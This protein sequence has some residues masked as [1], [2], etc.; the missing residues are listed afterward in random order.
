MAY[1]QRLWSAMLGKPYGEDMV[2][3]SREHGRWETE[4]QRYDVLDAYRRNDDLYGRLKGELKIR[5]YE[6]YQNIRNP[7]N[8]LIEFYASELPYKI[9]EHLE[10]GKNDTLKKL[11]QQVNEWSN[12]TDRSEVAARMFATH[13][14]LF[15]KIESSK[16]KAQVRKHLLDPRHVT[17]FDTD[18]R[19]T[20]TYLRLDIPQERRKADEVEEYTRT[21]VWDKPSERYFVYEHDEGPDADLEDL[22]AP[23]YSAVLTATPPDNPDT[24]WTGF[25]FIPVVHRKLKDTGGERGEGVFQHALDPIDQANY[26]ATKLMQMLFPKT[27]WKLTRQPGPGGITL[28]AAR[29]EQEAE[30]DQ[31]LSRLTAS[32]QES[33]GV[34]EE[35]NQQET[36]RLPAGTDLSP[37]VPALDFRS[38]LEALQAHMA[39][40]E[41]EM[42][43]LAY[44]RLRDMTEVSGVAARVLLDDVITRFET[45]RSKFED[46]EVR[47]NKMALTIAQVLGIEGY[48]ALPENAYTSGALDHGFTLYELFPVNPLDL[49]RTATE[50]ARA[51]Q[52]WEK[53]G[54]TLYARYLRSLGYDDEE[55]QQIAQASAERENPEDRQRAQIDGILSGNIPIGGNGA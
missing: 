38:H 28:P 32:E 15:I 17:D 11:I 10:T 50:E 37:M 29:I 34:I 24:I 39:E 51:A 48:A 8:R 13:G 22:G 40:L 31:K 21:E 14:D 3:T 12:W 1:F 44:Y 49:A 54:P 18:P 16:D 2:R 41:K 45:A 47:A 55:A 26:L 4:T 6:G 35:G 7:A 52:E 5:G 53:L 33:F 19:G 9:T 43:E 27:I 23:K 46:A 36:L 25:D 30:S 20:F 42:P